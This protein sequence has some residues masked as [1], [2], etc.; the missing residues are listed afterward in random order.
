MPHPDGIDQLMPAGDAR[1]P[2]LAV[3]VARR[4]EAR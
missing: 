3:N 2:P 1:I 4:V